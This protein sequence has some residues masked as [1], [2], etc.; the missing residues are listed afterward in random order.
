MCIKILTH[1]YTHIDK[2]VKNEK[3][4]IFEHVCIR[5]KTEQ[6][7]GN[8]FLYMRTYI[9]VYTHAY[10]FIFI[11]IYCEMKEERNEERFGERERESASGSERMYREIQKMRHRIS[12][13]SLSIQAEI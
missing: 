7:H 5:T 6:P 3:L 13:V 11:T 10:V 4:Y 2:I 1:M 12:S 9:C 8:Q